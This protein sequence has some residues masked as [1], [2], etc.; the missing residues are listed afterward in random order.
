MKHHLSSS[1]HAFV[2]DFESGNFP[3]E[4]FNHREHLRLAYAYLA[5]H[6][7][8]TAVHMM[9]DSLI[10]FLHHNGI[11]ISKYHETLTRAWVLAVRHF[12]DKTESSSSSA[13]FI[14]RNPILLDPKIMLTHYS[15]RLIFSDEARSRF[16]RPDLDPIPNPDA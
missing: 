13:E 16:V 1:D 5:G 7:T 12:M 8:D 10:R 6:S 2:S 11:E 15:A 4:D 9:R 14:D 3:P